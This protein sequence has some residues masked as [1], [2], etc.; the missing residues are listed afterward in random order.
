MGLYMELT[1]PFMGW[2]LIFCVV[3][4]AFFV[5]VNKLWMYHGPEDEEEWQEGDEHFVITYEML[6]EKEA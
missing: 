2:M 5:L 4:T 6:E 1:W 3:G